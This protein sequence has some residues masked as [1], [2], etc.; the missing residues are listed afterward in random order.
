MTQAVIEL[1]SARSTAVRVGMFVTS[2]K[3]Q[4]SVIGACEGEA[5]GSTVG[6]N[7]GTDDGVFEGVF[8]GISEGNSDGSNDGSLD[9]G[10]VGEAQKKSTFSNEIHTRGRSFEN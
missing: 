3:H 9:G 8:V 2:S 7:E 1:S 4:P 5:V 6:L 10:A